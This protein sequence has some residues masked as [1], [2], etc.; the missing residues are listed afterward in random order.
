MSIYKYGSYNDR[1]RITVY[2]ESRKPVVQRPDILRAQW[3]DNS[4]Y[5]DMTAELK[6]KGFAT[7][8]CG[9]FPPEE[10]NLPESGDK[11]VMIHEGK[12]DISLHLMHVLMKGE[13]CLKLGLD[14]GEIFAVDDCVHFVLTNVVGPIP[15]TRDSLSFLTK[16]VLSHYWIENYLTPEESD[17][18]K[19]IFNISHAIS[20]ITDN[21][22]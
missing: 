1:I 7:F 19:R 17:T 10:Q 16:D 14:Q 21:S 6:D 20:S 2:I 8:R 5:D 22:Q 18:F 13:D 11:I 12:K 4:E 15:A 9:G 3:L